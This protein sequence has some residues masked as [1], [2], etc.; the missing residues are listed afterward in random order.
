MEDKKMDTDDLRNT[1]NRS[2][3]FNCKD[4]DEAFT[5][6]YTMWLESQLLSKN[7]VGLADSS[8]M[9]DKGRISELEREVNRLK[10]YTGL[11]QF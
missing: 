8:E 10:E 4:G 7:N 2:V 11:D 5:D 3:H 9:S 6:E 1:F